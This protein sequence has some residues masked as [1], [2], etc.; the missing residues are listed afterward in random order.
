MILTVQAESLSLLREALASSCDRV[1]FGSEFCEFKVPSLSELEEAYEATVKSG[2]GFDYVTPRCVDRTLKGLKRHFD[3]LAGKEDT[4]IVVN[5]LGV[6]SILTEYG[7]LKLHLG[8]QLVHIPAR[9]PWFKPD[10]RSFVFAGFLVKGALMRRRVNDLYS[11]TSLNYKPTLEFYR[12][13]GVR[14]VDLDWIPRCFPEYRFIVESGFEVSIYTYLIPVTITRKCHTARF[15][16]EES[17]WRC[18]K[19]CEKR[20]FLLRYNGVF[21]TLKLLLQGNA[22]FSLN[23]PSR[24]GLETLRRIG[25]KEL[26]VP[27]SPA[28]GTVSRK[29]MEEALSNIRKAVET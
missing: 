22:V 8:R 7:N 15:L 20:G 29:K 17:L 23:K 10:S 12:E 11:Q 14:G 25:V 18:S 19:P 27:S 1:R 16:G 13:K 9:C 28:I 21:M 4:K 6:L 2:K 3:F 24:K 5:D 26:V